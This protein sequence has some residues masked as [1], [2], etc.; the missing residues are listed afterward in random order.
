MHCIDMRPV[1]DIDIASPASYVQG[2]YANYNRVDSGPASASAS[3]TDFRRK[4]K[5]DSKLASAI[6]SLE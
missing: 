6:S 2:S 4:H 3:L 1:V 5:R